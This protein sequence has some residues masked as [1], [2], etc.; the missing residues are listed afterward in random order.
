MFGSTSIFY[1]LDLPYF[2]PTYPITT[3]MSPDILQIFP[4]KKSVSFLSGPHPHHPEK[5]QFSLMK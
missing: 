3:K 1:P 5:Y 4:G 2:L